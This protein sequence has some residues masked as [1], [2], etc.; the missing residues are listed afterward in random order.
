M[1]WFTI[2]HLWITVQ[3]HGSLN[4]CSRLFVFMASCVDTALRTHYVKTISNFTNLLSLKECYRFNHFLNKKQCNSVNT[5]NKLSHF[6]FTG[7]CKSVF[8]WFEDLFFSFLQSFSI[9]QMLNLTVSALLLWQ[10]TLYW[11]YWH[12]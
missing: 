6:P 9:T 8:K 1:L 5:V 11:D 2:R 10:I 3:W 12:F 7:E 4:M